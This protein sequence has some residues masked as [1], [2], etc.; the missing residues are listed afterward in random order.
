M[1]KKQEPS[2]TLTTAKTVPLGKSFKTDKINYFLLTFPFD[3]KITQ[4]RNRDKTRQT[5]KFKST[6]TPKSKEIIMIF[7]SYANNRS[8]AYLN[9]EDDQSRRRDVEER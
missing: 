7:A 6:E 5:N 9:E 2:G 3:T 1:N 8:F 4:K